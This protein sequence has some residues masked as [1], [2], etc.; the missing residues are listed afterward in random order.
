MVLNKISK[1]VKFAI[2][3]SGSIIF[4]YAQFLKHRLRF[5]FGILDE[6]QMIYLYLQFYL[7]I[8]GRKS[9]CYIY[10]RFLNTCLRFIFSEILLLR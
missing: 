6:K 4:I 5:Y 8:F 7:S 1:T 2:F 10:A 3:A 9:T